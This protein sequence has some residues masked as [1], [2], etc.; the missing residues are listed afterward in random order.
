[1]LKSAVANAQQAAQRQNTPFDA[2]LAGQYAVVNEGQTLKRLRPAMGRG[3]RFSSARA[4]R[5]SRPGEAAPVAGRPARNGRGEGRAKAKAKRAPRRRRAEA[6]KKQTTRKRASKW[7]R[8][9]ILRFRL[10]I[11]KPWRSRYYARHNSRSCS[12]K[13]S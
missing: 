1:V 2:E 8:K 10:G 6:K 11:V 4:R 13:T 5:D 12:R 7:D 9:H 3:T